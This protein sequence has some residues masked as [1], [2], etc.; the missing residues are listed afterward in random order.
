MKQ[1]TCD[2]CGG[3]GKVTPM[4]LPR[5][6]ETTLGFM[7]FDLCEPCANVVGSNLQIFI[8]MDFSKFAQEGGSNDTTETHHE[9]AQPRIGKNKE[10][11]NDGE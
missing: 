1:I 9:A 5:M 2:R 4:G 10:Q 8:R 11:E 3:D 7:R 6:L